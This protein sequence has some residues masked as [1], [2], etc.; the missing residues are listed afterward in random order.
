M[1]HDLLT[2]EPHREQLMEPPREPLQHMEGEEE[3][4]GNRHLP[5]ELIR[6]RQSVL[7]ADSASQIMVYML[8]LNDCIAW[9]K[10]IMKVVRFLRYS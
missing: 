7:T 5:K 4:D 10:S 1:E 2:E 6:W 8:Q 9:E 3:N